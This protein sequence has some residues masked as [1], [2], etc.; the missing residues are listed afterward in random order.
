MV[1]RRVGHDGV[2]RLPPQGMGEHISVAPCHLCARESCPGPL[3]HRGIDVDGDHER[4]TARE[5]SCEEAVTAA[6]LEDR[7]G[8][9]GHAGIQ[10]PVVVDV[11][12]LRAGHV[13]QFAA[14]R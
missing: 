1:Q 9:G 10:P 8:R 14:G 13:A 4:D 12:V 6:H 2:K 7:P 3:E 11:G 5:T